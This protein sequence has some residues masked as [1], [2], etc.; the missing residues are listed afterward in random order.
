[1]SG[2]V[3]AAYQPTTLYER[4]GLVEIIIVSSIR[5]RLSRRFTSSIRIGRLSVCIRLLVT[6]GG[7]EI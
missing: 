2:G 1:M 4:H 6:A 3:R 5:R 7:N